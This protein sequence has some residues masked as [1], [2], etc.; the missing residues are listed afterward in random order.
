[1]NSRAAG[2]NLVSPLLDK[3]HVFRP[4]SRTILTRPNTRVAI[5]LGMDNY[6]DI[7]L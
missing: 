7:A 2:D 5:E 6:T 1:V 3:V 4:A